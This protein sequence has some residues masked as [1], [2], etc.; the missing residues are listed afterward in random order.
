MTKIL[1]GMNYSPT[2]IGWSPGQPGQFSDSDFFNDAFEAMWNKGK[3]SGSPVY[4]YRDDLG[5]ID[6][7]TGGQPE[8]G[9]ELRVM[10]I[11]MH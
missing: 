3:T 7:L 8:V 4:N 11:S 1:R 6:C 9:M 5:V 10:D 2:W